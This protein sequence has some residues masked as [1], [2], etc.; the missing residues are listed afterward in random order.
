MRRWILEQLKDATF[1]E[2]N[3]DDVLSDDPRHG[4][5]AKK[6]LIARGDWKN[7][8]QNR[9]TW[10]GG[11]CSLY[12]AD[13]EAIRAGT[14]IPTSIPAFHFWIRGWYPRV[15]QVH[16]CVGIPHKSCRR[17]MYVVEDSFF[18]RRVAAKTGLPEDE[19]TAVFNE[20]HRESGEGCVVRWLQNFGYHGEV[21][22][23][24]TSEMENELDLALRIWER[25]TGKRIKPT[26]RD[27]AKVELM[28]MSVWLDVLGIRSGIIAEPID[29]FQRTL[30]VLWPD[31]G[32]CQ[33][34][35]L[36]FWSA[37]G[38]T[39]NLPLTEVV[40]RGNWQTFR[41]ERE[42][43]AVNLAFNTRDPLNFSI[44]QM[45]ARA[46]KDLEFVYEGT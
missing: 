1:L 40:H 16:D 20:I 45:Q 41:T 5:M 44:K 22:A 30:S 27:W 4:A 43:T 36:P 10:L 8:D 34:G 42:W 46:L 23:I 15:D 26:L 21:T 19:L 33:I 3:G 31:T 32:L 39:R 38:R 37:R 14:F 11:M 6:V 9:A 2:G 35:Y 29:N 28:Y 25:N 24:Y 17:V 18:A 12:S 7:F 13:W